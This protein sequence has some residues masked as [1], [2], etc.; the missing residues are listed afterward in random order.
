MHCYCSS[1]CIAN[2][3]HIVHNGYIIHA[4]LFLVRRAKE[5]RKKNCRSIAHTKWDKEH[6]IK[7]T[8]EISQDFCIP[9]YVDARLLGMHFFFGVAFWHEKPLAKSH[10]NCWNNEHDF[11]ATKMRFKTI[12]FYFLKKK[13]KLQRICTYTYLHWNY[14][15]NWKRKKPQF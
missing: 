4:N 8:F 2:N 5:R 15:W 14:E 7:F 9:N 6:L 11:N 3:H 13:K 1:K 12:G 10:S